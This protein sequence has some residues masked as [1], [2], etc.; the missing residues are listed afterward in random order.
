MN[1]EEKKKKKDYFPAVLF[2]LGLLS[3]I[4]VH[5]LYFVTTPVE[6]LIRTTALSVFVI[7]I[8]YFIK[9]A[10]KDTDFRP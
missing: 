10:F 1:E 8:Y 7:L 9:E 4:G 5:I 6:E 2:A 3:F